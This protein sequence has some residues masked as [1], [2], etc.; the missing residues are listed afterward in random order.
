MSGGDIMFKVLVLNS[1]LVFFLFFNPPSVAF[2]ATLLQEMHFPQ[3][4]F[5]CPASLLLTSW[6]HVSGRFLVMTGVKGWSSSKS[7]CLRLMDGMDG[8]W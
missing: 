3:R 7:V 5:I 4:S 2:H 1:S 8:C 6:S